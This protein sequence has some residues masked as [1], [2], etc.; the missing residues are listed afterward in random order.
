MAVEADFEHVLVVWVGM[1]ASDG[2]ERLHVSV[3]IGMLVDG[4]VGG[5]R[6]ARFSIVDFRRSSI[7]DPGREGVKAG[8]SLLKI[9]P[10][11]TILIWLQNHTDL[12]T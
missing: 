3:C 11:R 5:G 6:I 2:R 8:V 1:R 9:G 4:T 12:A 7:L 10:S